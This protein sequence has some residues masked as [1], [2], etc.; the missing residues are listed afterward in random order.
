MKKTI[1]PILLATAW[2][3]LSEFVRNEL[4]FKSYWT[5]HY[6]DLGI[7]FPSQ[8]INNAMWGVWSLL[9]AILIFY[10]AKRYTLLQTIA[11][12]WGAGFVMM[13]IAVGNLGVLPFGLLPIAVPLSLLEAGIAALI[14]KSYAA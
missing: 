7:T 3:G 5:D 1:L 11:L 4:L 14:V 2:I 8:M 13:W 9:F 12:S 10:I 6:Q